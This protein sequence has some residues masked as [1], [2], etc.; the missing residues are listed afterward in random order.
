MQIYIVLILNFI[1]TIIG[2][3]AYSVRLVG[4]RTGKI[5][6]SFAIFNVF[7][8]ISRTAV[9]FQIPILTKYI[10]QSSET[11][12]T[13][14]LRIF[15]LIIIVSGISTVIGAFMI[16]SFQRFLTKSVQAFSVHR[17]IPKILFHSLTK[18]GI[19]HIKD[20]AAIPV[21]ENIT[22]LSIKKLPSKTIILNII[23]VSILT[24]GSLAPIYAGCIAPDLRATCITL[25]SVITGIAA[26]LMSVFIDPQLS[27][28]TDDVVEGKRSEQEFRACVVG[29]VCSKTAGTFL[30]LLIFLPIAYLIV[31]IARII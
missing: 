28:M 17:S 12:T 16:P 18:S 9:T 7:A 25:S 14:L 11:S 5:A 15:I 2:T 27:I 4:I 13:G 23:A 20:C 29:M 1:I 3:M 8:L 21:K 22:K 30:A 6:I 31:L 24:A 10:E 26:I 19:R